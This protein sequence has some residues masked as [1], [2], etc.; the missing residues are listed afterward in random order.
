MKI[1]DKGKH[2][3]ENLIRF[4]SGRDR[5]LDLLLAP[6]DVLGTLAH[7]KM[8][9]SVNLLDAEEGKTICN[10]LKKIHWNF[11]ESPVSIPDEYEDI[12][13]WLEHKLTED[14]GD[15]G[16]KIHMGR[17]RND[18]VLVAMKLYFRES[19]KQITGRVEKLFGLLLDLSERHKEVLMPGYTHMQ[20]AMPSSFGLWFGAF[21]ESLADDMLMM[22][23]AYNICNQNPLGSAAG[24]G[25]SFPIDRELTTGLLG[26][27]NMHVNSVYAQMTRGKTELWMAMAMAEVGGTLARLSGDIC[28][29]MSQN[30]G[31]V[32]LPDKW[33]TGSSIMPHKKN[34]D[35][36]E[37]IR[38]NCNRIRSIPGEIRM[39]TGNL[40][41]G[42]HRDLQLVK[43]IIFPAIESLRD[44]LDMIIPVTAEIQVNQ[45]IL[46]A[47]MYRSLFSVE[48]VHKLVIKGLPF[49]EAYRQVALNQGEPGFDADNHPEYT[50]PGSIGNPGN[51]I[52]RGKMDVLLKQF[53]YKENDRAISRLL[54]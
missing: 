2:T 41:T 7:V 33:T 49:R 51:D 4:T 23:T 20:I 31:F 8:L 3:D 9:V 26:F 21:A 27:D 36:F 46:E 38:A 30:F 48:E 11:V 18:Q 5:E 37:L 12:H 15:L 39:I 40:E 6:Y 1:W 50:H 16:K 13:S 22:L 43:E 19:L 44:C 52:I 25:S 53:K 47:E 14:L 34:P 24:Y 29:Y 28:L 35:V 17:S 54:K 42:Y 32:S 45:H 10:A